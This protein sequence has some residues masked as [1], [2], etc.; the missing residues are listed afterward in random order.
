[1]QRSC[2]KSLKTSVIQHANAY[3]HL[4]A[5]SVMVAQV[6]QHTAAFSFSLPQTRLVAPCK[7]LC[8]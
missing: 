1:M 4:A 5:Y 3:I 2:S 8:Q 7:A 6:L